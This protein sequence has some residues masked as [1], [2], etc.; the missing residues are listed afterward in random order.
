MSDPGTPPAKTF[1][2]DADAAETEA[3]RAKHSE[4]TREGRTTHR[5]PTKTLLTIYA[6]TAFLA[7]L[8]LAAIVIG[9]HDAALSRTNFGVSAVSVVLLLTGVVLLVAAVQL[10]E[11]VRHRSW[12]DNRHPP[13]K[14]PVIIA[15]LLTI[16]LAI[17]VFLSGIRSR[18]AQRPIVVAVAIALIVVGALGLSFFGRDARVTIPRIGTIA[19]G[20]IG[21]IFAAWQF[22]YQNQYAPAHA[23]QAVALSATI[24]R[25]DEQ[26]A[27]D[28]IKA[29][30][31]YEDT[32]S[33]SVS[34]IGSTYTLTGSRVVR[35]QRAASTKY[36]QSDFQGMLP[37]PQ[38]T[39]FMADV[40]ED[41]P[42]TV[43]AAGKFVGDGKRLD[44]NVSAGRDFIFL[45][46]R[47]HYQL[48]RFRTQLFAIP[49][50]VQISQRTPPTYTPLPG[51]N[52]IFGFWHVD[53]DS[54]LHDLVNGRER[55]IVL[56]YELVNRPTSTNISPD[57]RITAR[58]PD[59]TWGEQRPSDSTVNK[60]FKTTQPS[61]ASEPFADTEA[62]LE[63][64][65][66]PTP[67]DNVPTSCRP[68]P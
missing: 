26:A 41:R 6:F 34:V 4:A 1:A 23:G 35:C 36:V 19:L 48:L 45:V 22:W 64:I 46:P 39:R 27:Y 62:P 44:P 15:F 38:R 51:S 2:A 61:D 52:D 37:D 20:V 31:S 60:L 8:G 30:I 50:S 65:A 33:R 42:A 7:V 3:G 25:V 29:S 18:G 12:T 11:M 68:A 10:A 59:P 49:A 54:W 5:R 55:W 24:N 28:V 21:T 17:Y 13:C 63:P 32:S 66:Q 53:D 16:L 14:L 43:L 67:G 47:H 58:F 40:W 56:R 9:G 57:L